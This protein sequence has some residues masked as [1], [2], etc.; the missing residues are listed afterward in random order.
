[1]ITS[2]TAYTG[3]IGEDE[4]GARKA[5]KAVG[6]DTSREQETLRPTAESIHVARHNY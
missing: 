3:A 1:M 2:Q 5:G 4:K 6:R